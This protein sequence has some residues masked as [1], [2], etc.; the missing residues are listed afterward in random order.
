MKHFLLSFSCMI[1]SM[2]VPEKSKD[3]LALARTIAEADLKRIHGSGILREFKE[4]AIRGNVIDLAIGIM[5]GGAFNK[6]TTSLVNDIVMPPIGYVL[7]T[8]KFEDLYFNLSSRE[9][10]SLDAAKAAGAPTINYGAFLNT[11][12]DFII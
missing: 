8:V 12:F 6:I 5:V 3:V 7:G 1:A 11:F 4:F 10:P 2:N 9:Y